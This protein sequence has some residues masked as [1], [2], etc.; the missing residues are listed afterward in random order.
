MS[1]QHPPYDVSYMQRTRDFYRAQGYENAYQ[2]ARN[3]TTP[4]TKLLKPLAQ[5]RLAVI[6][7]AMP[8][9]AEGRSRRDVYALPTSPPPKAMYTAELSWDKLSTHTADL[10]SFLPLAALEE[11]QTLGEIGSLSPSFF[12]VPT[13]YSQRNTQERDAPLLLEKLRSEAADIALLVPL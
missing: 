5:S 7:T 2:W 10:G 9:T 11:R 13:D 8:D 12:T 6:T 1:R 3:E 4:F